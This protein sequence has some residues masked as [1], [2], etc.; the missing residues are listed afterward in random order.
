MRRSPRRVTQRRERRAHWSG[1]GRATCCLERRFEA[2]EGM[3]CPT[4]EK[5]LSLADAVGPEYQFLVLVAGASGLHLGG[6]HPGSPDRR[7]TFCGA[8]SAQTT[9]LSS[10]ATGGS[11]SGLRR[12]RP[13]ACHPREPVSRDS[14]STICATGRALAP[15]VPERPPSR[16]MARLGHASPHAA[17][18]Y[19]HVVAGRD[20]AIA[21]AMDAMVREADPRGARRELQRAGSGTPVARRRRRS[22]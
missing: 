10:A 19:Q 5:I 8:R 1:P 9:K 7:S 12:P 20:A 18:R 14:G 22:A 3:R 16:L 4:I 11:R 17:R 15:P 13:A 6:V 2:A 21:E